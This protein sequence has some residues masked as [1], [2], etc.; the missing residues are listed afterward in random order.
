MDH[1]DTAGWDSWPAEVALSEATSFEERAHALTGI[2][3]EQLKLQIGSPGEEAPG[4]RWESATRELILQ[5][6][7]DLR[8][9]NLLPHVIVSFAV[10]AGLVARVAYMPKWR[11]CPPEF[12]SKLLGAYAPD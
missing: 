4:T 6:D 5:A 8:Y 7:R 3:E 10:S 12:A 9:F 11:R 2:S 1:A